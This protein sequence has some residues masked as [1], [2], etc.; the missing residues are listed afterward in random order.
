MSNQNVNYLEV[1]LQ[2]QYEVKIEEWIRSLLSNLRV[3]R[4]NLQRA[5][6]DSETRKA[7]IVGT[8]VQIS[9]RFI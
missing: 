8:E 9:A 7:V 1:N 3:V 2:F 6:F 4:S 5:T